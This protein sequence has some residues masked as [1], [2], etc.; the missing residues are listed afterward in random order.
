[1][2]ESTFPKVLLPYTKT[3]INKIGEAF[4]TNP[5]NS[6][7]T[8]ELNNVMLCYTEVAGRLKAHIEGV[9][10]LFPEQLP[11]LSVTERVK[12]RDTLLSKMKK[13]KLTLTNV[14]DVVG[15]RVE[16][17]V[18]TSQ[19]F[20]IAQ[21]LKSAFISH[22]P[23]I[24]NYLD[25][26]GHSGYRAIHIWLNVGLK[27]EIQIRTTLQGKW[28][29]LYEVAADVI[30]REIRYDWFPEDPTERE[31]VKA[32][33]DL[34]LNNV[35]HVE[36][37]EENILSKRLRISEMELRG[38]TVKF[39]TRLRSQLRKITNEIAQEEQLLIGVKSTMLKNFEEL[40]SLFLKIRDGR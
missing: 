18:T 3:R 5:D 40:E 8:I 2:T 16:A 11:S 23:E 14:Q 1:M 6:H 9:L 12:T 39:P 31:V 19:Q 38:E 34:S 17:D 20:E 26:S 10:E 21:F 36:N 35:T 37:F 15:L 33:Q 25:G 29:N 22:S 28:A 32:L 7:A 4:I 30:G 13:T 27:V 24:K